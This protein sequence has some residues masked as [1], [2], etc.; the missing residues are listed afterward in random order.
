MAE[1]TLSPKYRECQIE[2]GHFAGWGS[3]YSA[4]SSDRVYFINRA[5]TEGLR[6]FYWP[7]RLP[8]Q[9]KPHRWSFLRPTEKLVTVASYGTG[10]IELVNGDATVTLTDGVFPSWS[11]LGELAV[12]GVSYPIATRTDDTHVEIESA[13]DGTSASGLT[14]RVDRNAYTLPDAFGSIDG[15]ITFEQESGVLHTVQIIGEGQVRELRQGNPSPGTPLF[16]AIRPIKSVGADLTGQR[17]ELILVPAADK[18]Y[19][20]SY[21]CRI[22]PDAMSS[23][24][25]ETSYPL[26]GSV[27][28]QTIIDSCV[29][30]AELRI[31][32]SKGPRWERFMERLEASIALDLELAPATLGKNTNRGGRMSPR[33]S[34]TTYVTYNGVLYGD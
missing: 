2:V 28:G 30:A 21:R 31:S 22:N 32:G 14:Y 3:T 6:Q 34:R 16:A 27:H 17:W 24:L 11:A 29:A 1:S 7:P 23:S 18:A 4:Y 9:T 8:N 5:V 20:M 19:T 12:N 26:G 13:W 15:E 25:S 33:Q 10:T